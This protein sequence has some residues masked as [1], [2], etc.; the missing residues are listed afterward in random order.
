MSAANRFVWYELMT[1]DQPAAVDFYRRVVGWTAQDAGMPGAPYTLLL[2]G[3]AKV[4]G[5]M[6]TPLELAG[7]G[8]AP[9]WSG[10]IGVADVD[11]AAADVIGAG[12]KLLR[13]VAAI[14]GVGRFAV[15]ADPQGASF[16]L[17][18][19]DPG[20]PPAAAPAGTPGTIGWHELH[21]VDGPAALTFYR[22]LF[23]WTPG[24]TMDMGPNG[25][26]RLFEIDGV[27]AGGF[28]DKAPD[29]PAPGWDF[30]FNVDAIDAAVDRL[31]AAGGELLMGPH[32]VPGGS[33]IAIARD[34]QG[35]G[36]SLVAARR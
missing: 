6:T 4:A 19:P 17:F 8:Q 33:W 16:A 22:R 21:A 2:A 15:A 34:P 24:E 12:G 36:F 25:V 7:I 26:Y 28:V 35:A 31:R 5:V 11:A 29:R 30:Y 27:P 10:Y 9:S 13:P 1:G 23:G 32:E 3:P 18:Q 14:P 20:D